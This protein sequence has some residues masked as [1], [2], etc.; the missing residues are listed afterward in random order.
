MTCP[1]AGMAVEKRF[2]EQL[3]GVQQL[4]FMGGQLALPYA[5]TDQSF[6]VMLFE[7]RAK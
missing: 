5:K 2:T 4:R 3:A 7:R 1:E 6:G